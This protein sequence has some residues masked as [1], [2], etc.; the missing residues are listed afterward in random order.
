MIALALRPDPALFLCVEEDPV[1]RRLLQACFDV[2]GAGAVFAASASQALTQFRRRP[3]DLVLMDFDIHAAAELAAFVTMR[4]SGAVPIL[5]VTENECH[6]SEADYREA[7]F[8]GLFEKPLE[9]GRLIATID[10]VLRETGQPP[11]LR[12]PRAAFE[13]AFAYLH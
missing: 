4:E 10:R 9:P 8:A 1:Q 7:G 2:A 6:W 12:E 5:A 11:L 13:P 3:F